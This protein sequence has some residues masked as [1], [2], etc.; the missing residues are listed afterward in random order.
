MPTIALMLQSC[1]RMASAI[2]KLSILYHTHSQQSE[3]E[4]RITFAVFSRA[5]CLS[6][7]HSNKA[8]ITFDISNH[9]QFSL[10]RSIIFGTVKGR[11]LR[12]VSSKQH[13]STLCHTFWHRKWQTAFL[14]TDVFLITTG[15]FGLFSLKHYCDA[16]LHGFHI[17]GVVLFSTT[18]CT[19][20]LARILLVVHTFFIYDFVDALLF[21][22]FKIELTFVHGAIAL[23][24]RCQ[25]SLAFENIWV[26]HKDC[27]NSCPVS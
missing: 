1:K 7:Q 22:S 16:F 3:M 25:I 15:P 4:S 20:L 8:H 13:P 11:S 10:E 24:H 21:I 14:V 26:T 19:W 12:A 6:E 5:Q 2:T 18:E 17:F 9:N 23:L 27:V